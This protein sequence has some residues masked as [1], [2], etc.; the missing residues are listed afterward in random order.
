M[1]NLANAQY[2]LGM[3]SGVRTGLRQ[4][5]VDDQAD[6][7]REH[8]LERR[9]TDDAW[10]DETRTYA[11]GQRTAADQRS[12]VQ[13]EDAQL[14]LNETKQRIQ[15]E[16]ALDFMYELDS[17]GDP[18]QAAMRHNMRG[19]SKIDE[20]SVQYDPTSKT[21]KFNA[22]SDGDGTVEP[23]E[24]NVPSTINAMERIVGKSKGRYTQ[25]AY[26][27]ELFDNQT[28]KIV[29]SNPKDVT[30]G[31]RASDPANRR[32]FRG[33]KI[34]DGN[35]NLVKDTGTGGS[36]TRD[37]TLF[38]PQTY[39]KDVTNSLGKLLGG[40][41]DPATDQFDFAGGTQKMVQL[42]RIAQR[43]AQRMARYKGA[44][45][46][47]MVS[48][49]VADLA[50]NFDEKAIRAQAVTDA[51]TTVGKDQRDGA[52]FGLGKIK[53]KVLKDLQDTAVQN[54]LA[55]LEADV[56]TALDAEVVRGVDANT[57]LH[58]GGL[59]EPSGDADDDAE[60][61]ADPDDPTATAADN[62]EA[63]DWPTD[64]PPQEKFRNLQRGQGVRNKKTGVIWFIGDDG[65]LHNRK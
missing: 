44:I 27:A 18:K 30:S 56:Q 17:G 54:A 42:T 45:T 63:I 46:A 31:G 33:G 39:S 32:L 59:D 62:Q 64:A 12:Q 55:K 41:Y 14:K 3:A 38:N 28:G 48:G 50:Q 8:T 20:D 19:M 58:N 53:P 47:D 6:V 60:G 52:V 57:G 49:V 36:G 40:K 29:A 4:N 7:D 37:T 25:V 34:F 65:Q 5:K 16:G 22:D 61:D 43:Q 11:R 23:F 1:A 9:K 15:D 26:G 21:V 2:E 24:Y 13:T 35:G 51:E 10:T